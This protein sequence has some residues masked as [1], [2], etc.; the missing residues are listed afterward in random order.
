MR[1]LPTFRMVHGMSNEWVDR[2]GLR[3]MCGAGM[4]PGPVGDMLRAPDSRS[5]REW[6][7]GRA[8]DSHESRVS[9][10]LPGGRAPYVPDLNPDGTVSAYRAS[11]MGNI[12]SELENAL[13]PANFQ[14][15]NRSAY[16]GDLRAAQKFSGPKIGTHE[17]GHVRYDMNPRFLEELGPGRNYPFSGRSPGEVRLD[18]SGDVGVVDVVRKRAYEM[19]LGLQETEWGTVT[20][21]HDK[22]FDARLD[23]SKSPGTVMQSLVDADRAMFKIDVRPRVGQRL[24]VRHLGVWPDGILRLSHRKCFLGIPLARVRRRAEDKKKQ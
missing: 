16:V 3:I 14:G 2:A 1:D 6:T 4:D 7:A 20:A 5:G 9:G 23:T 24:R 13:S 11:K 10:G 21:V 17:Y 8:P 19:P 12:R 22:G 18:S 15:M